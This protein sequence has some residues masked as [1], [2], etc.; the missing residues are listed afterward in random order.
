MVFNLLSADVPQE[1]KGNQCAGESVICSHTRESRG[2]ALVAYQRPK[3]DGRLEG[4]HIYIGHLSKFKSRFNGEICHMG[5]RARRPQRL[6]RQVWPRP[7]LLMFALRRCNCGSS[8][9]ETKNG[10]AGLEGIVALPNACAK[11]PAQVFGTR[12]RGAAG[13]PDANP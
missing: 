8:V 9:R 3:L 13:G 5:P 7:I 2:S 6:H 11:T 4:L 1:P 10:L 12:L